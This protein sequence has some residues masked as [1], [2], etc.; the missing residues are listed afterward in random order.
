MV[1]G[2]PGTIG[3]LPVT[4]A[5]DGGCEV[6]YLPVLAMLKAADRDSEVHSALKVLS[7][8]EADLTHRCTR[9]IT[10]FRGLLP[11]I[12]PPLE[13]AFPGTVLTRS[14]VLEMLIKIRGSH[15]SSC[16]QPRELAALGQEP[17]PQ[18]R[19]RVR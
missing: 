3:S 1:V 4:V 14:L 16:R 7:G 9:A 11:Q 12:F 15:R 13:R 18:G 19:G 8:F 2:Q 10:R 17:Q 6:A 5:G